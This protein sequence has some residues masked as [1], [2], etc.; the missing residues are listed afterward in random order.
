M[1][2]KASVK[3]NYI[4]ILFWWK[5]LNKR[6]YSSNQAH[7]FVNKIHYKVVTCGDANKPPWNQ[8]CSITT[9][10]SNEQLFWTNSALSSHHTCHMLSSASQL[11][12]A[13]SMCVCVFTFQCWCNPDCVYTTI[14][15]Y[16]THTQIRR[17]YTKRT[18]CLF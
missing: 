11:L 4:N 8:C 18:I 2:I 5:C 9:Q 12:S 15:K 10:N 3:N 1:Y 16:N 13:P 14:R 17:S 7:V 6:Q